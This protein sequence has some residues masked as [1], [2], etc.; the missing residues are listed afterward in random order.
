MKVPILPIICLATAVFATAAAS[1]VRLSEE[2]HLWKSEHGKSYEDEV[3]ELERHSIWLS[4]K[5]YI[6]QHNTRS[7]VFGYTLKMNKFGDLVS[8]VALSIA[9]FSIPFLCLLS[10]H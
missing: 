9:G 4:N 10:H 5:E 1:P 7:D 6:E 3:E 2:W 8:S